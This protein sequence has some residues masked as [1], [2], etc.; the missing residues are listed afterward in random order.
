M[1]DPNGS[2]V[3]SARAAGAGRGGGPG[4]R[5]SP[6]LDPMHGPGVLVPNLELRAPLLSAFSGRFR[7]GALPLDAFA[8]ADAGTTWGAI[9]RPLRGST[10]ARA[11]IRTGRRRG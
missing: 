11:L 7:Y 5:R 8:F 4:R 1:L 6:A 9:D 3:A 10:M 2:V